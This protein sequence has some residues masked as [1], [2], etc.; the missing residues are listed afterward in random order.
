MSERSFIHD[1]DVYYAPLALITIA[2]ALEA[3]RGLSVLATL[4]FGDFALCLGGIDSWGF[5]YDVPSRD[6]GSGLAD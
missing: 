5:N 3:V 1:G 6:V 4:D 2:D